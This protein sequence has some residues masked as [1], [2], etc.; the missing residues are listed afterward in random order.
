[1]NPA[2]AFT[3]DELAEFALTDTPRILNSNTAA[4]IITQAA[5]NTLPPLQISHAHQ[6]SYERCFRCDMGSYMVYVNTSTYHTCQHKLC[7]R[8]MHKYVLGCVADRITSIRCPI[9]TC[10]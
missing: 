3:F 2:N 5:N 4:Q 7:Q 9:R 8:C 10:T 6:Q 1:M